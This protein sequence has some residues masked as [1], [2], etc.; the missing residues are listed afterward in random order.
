MKPHCAAMSKDGSRGNIRPVNPL[1]D[2]GLR[3]M[4]LCKL[5]ITM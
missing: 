5:L 2:A 1:G 3:K 4:T